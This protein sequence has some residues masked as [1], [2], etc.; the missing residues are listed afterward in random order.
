MR[1]NASRSIRRLFIVHR[2]GLV[3][4]D[5]SN[6]PLA[7][8]VEIA[9]LRE[10][11]AFYESF[12]Q[13]IHENVNQSSALLRKAAETQEQTHRVLKTASAQHEKAR[14]AERS[15]FRALFSTMLDEVTALQGQLE[16][17]ARQVADSLDDLESDH[18]M[19]SLPLTT[20]PPV[21]LGA[22]DYVVTPPEAPEVEA[23]APGVTAEDLDASAPN[24]EPEGI[25]PFSADS[26]APGV[27]MVETSELPLRGEPETVAEP[28]PAGATVL[29][30]G[31]PRATTALS[32]K[33]FLE[34]LPDVDQVEPRE[35][36][37]GVLRLL[38]LSRRPV[39]I[40][41]LR[42]WTEGASLEPINVRDNLLELRLNS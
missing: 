10:R 29:V 40:Q 37:E 28:I 20:A 3:M 27:G 42:A 41:D 12:D 30:H 2:E 14:R 16:R 21:E 7:S 33:R 6:P 23:V 18:P 5:Q 1:P 25:E 15:Q 34:N 8:D 11:L 19:E 35:Y 24:E 13:M 4:A 39:T 32:L 9:Q 36:A 17:L 26:Y 38:V 22:G 31:V